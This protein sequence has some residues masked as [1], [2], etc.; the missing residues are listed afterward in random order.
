[1][2]FL[3]HQPT[4]RRAKCDSYKVRYAYVISVRCDETVSCTASEIPPEG[5]IPCRNALQVMVI[6]IRNKEFCQCNAVFIKLGSANAC[7]EF[8]ETK[9]CISGTKLVC[10]SVN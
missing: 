6:W 9:M 4:D 5:L 1:M 7:E 8:R 10:A 2:E 3:L